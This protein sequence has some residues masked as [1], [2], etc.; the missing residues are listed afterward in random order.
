M[1]T[2]TLAVTNKV[3]MLVCIR[4]GAFCTKLGGTAEVIDF[5]PLQG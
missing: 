5:C 3:H 1:L 2:G 4:V